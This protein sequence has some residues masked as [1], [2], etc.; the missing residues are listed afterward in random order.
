M[1]SSEECGASAVIADF[2]AGCSVS[3][4]EGIEVEGMLV[5]GVFVPGIFGAGT[6]VVGAGTV[7][8]DIVGTG[9]S[10]SCLSF[11]VDGIVSCAATEPA[12]NTNERVASAN[13]FLQIT[14]ECLIFWSLLLTSKAS[15][16]QRAQFRDSSSS[17]RIRQHTTPGGS[18]PSITGSRTTRLRLTSYIRVDSIV[19]SRLAFSVFTII[20]GLCFFASTPL[21]AEEKAIRISIPKRSHL[22][23][24]QKLNQEGVKALNKRKIEDAKKSF[25]KA[26]LLDP[27]DPFT[28]NNLGYMAELEGEVDRAQRFYELSTANASDAIVAKSSNKALEGKTLAEVAGKAEGG[29]LEVNRLN[30]QAISLLQ[31]DRAIEAEA[32]L[33]KALKLE[34]ENPFTLN[35]MGY[36][37]EKQGELES[38]LDY[39]SHAART[40]SDEIIIVAVNENR[41]WRGQKIRDVAAKNADKVSRAMRGEES[42]E[43]KVARLNL[44]GVSALNRNDRQSARRYFQ[45]ANKL[46][47][48]NAFSLN[49]MGYVAE[50]DGD[51]ESANYYYGKAQEADG[52]SA[53]V[54]VSTRRDAEGKPLQHV[55]DSNELAV[56]SRMQI[57]LENK[58][59]S[60]QQQTPALKRRDNSTVPEPTPPATPPSTT[61]TPPQ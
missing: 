60:R 55:A 39:Y 14:K 42:L 3:L 40:N 38:A 59:R 58:R 2:A 4:T 34:P 54:G 20:L 57:D 11:S 17:R 33:Q 29:P 46:D 26:Y 24:V 47:P 27:N 10:E 1:L 8:A 19:K 15:W 32:V 45:E 48:S 52:S 50:L 18:F 13:T 25:Y 22:T 16:M 36:T 35:N 12:A 30:I 23:P 51:R 49:N 41:N 6:G 7:G 53:R 61:T 37:R 31:K 56:D 21:Q 9:L 43:A 5:A 44:R 28:L